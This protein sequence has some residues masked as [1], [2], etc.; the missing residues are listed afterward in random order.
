[1]S[2]P[3]VA[4]VIVSAGSSSLILDVLSQKLSNRRITREPA[5][6]YHLVECV[7][8]ALRNSNIRLQHE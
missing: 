1:M 8:G 6:F 5:V 2:Q 4:V 3:I 7:G